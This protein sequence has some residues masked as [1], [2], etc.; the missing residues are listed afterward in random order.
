MRRK[1]DKEA[2]KEINEESVKKEPV[3][4]FGERLRR[5]RRKKTPKESKKSDYLFTILLNTVLLYVLN[6]WTKERPGFITGNFALCLPIISLSLGATVFGNFLFLF[7][8]EEKFK[9]SVR[10]FLNFMSM[11]AI[12][13][14]YKNFPFDFSGFTLADMELLAKIGLLLG[15]VA[16]GVAAII[17]FFKVVFNTFDWK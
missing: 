8:E 1:L 10:I 9:S 2:V 12:Y 17:E 3:D 13:T 15:I 5:K 4:E 11:A 7:N 14:L 16:A 6:S